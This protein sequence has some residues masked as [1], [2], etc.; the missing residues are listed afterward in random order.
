MLPMRHND[1]GVGRLVAPGTYVVDDCEDRG[2][3]HFYCDVPT[4]IALFSGFD[5]LNLTQHEKRK[6]G[7]WHWNVIA[8]RAH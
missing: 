7:S 5:I 4:L 6:P 2:H 1:Y 3:A 8:E